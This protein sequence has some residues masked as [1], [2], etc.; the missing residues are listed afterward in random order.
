[1]AIKAPFNFVPLSDHVFFPD[2][3]DMISQ[4]IPFEEGLSGAIDLK[5]TALTPIFVRNGHTKEDADNV[6]NAYTTFSKAPDGRFFI[7]ATSIK[8]CIRNVLE[9]MSFGKMRLDK[10]ARFAQREWDNQTLYPIKSPQSQSRM[11]CGWL[12]WNEK[13][14][15]YVIA[16]SKK[17]YRI[18]HKR[19][20][21]IFPGDPFSI[22]NRSS[23]FDLNQET[24]I[25]QKT[26]DPKTAVYK[27]KLLESLGIDEVQLQHQPF[28]RDDQYAVEFKENRVKAANGTPDFWGTI[29]FTGQPD[30]ANWGSH[31]GMGDGKFY[32]FV[33]DDE[34]VANYDISE[35]T[36]EQYKFIYAD[37]PDWEF[38]KHKLFG[39][40]IPVFFRLDGDKVKDFGLAF[41]YKLP[42]EKT[43]YDTLGSNHKRTD[44]DLADCIFGTVNGQ[45]PL[46][47]R[48]QISNA[49]SSN[50]KPSN[51]YRLALGSPKASYYPLYIRQSG[52][53]GVTSRYMTYNDGTVAGWKR[54]MVRANAFERN[55]GDDKIDT[56]I[57]PLAPQ[58]EFSCKVRFH[59]LL[60]EELGALL[61]AITFHNTN[62]CYHQI[63]Q[64]KPYGFGKVDIKVTHFAAFTPDGEK[65][66]DVI[67]P[68]MYFEGLM[69]ESIKNS[70][71]EHDRIVQLFTMAHSEVTADDVMDYMQLSVDDKNNEFSAAKVAGEYLNAYTQLSNAHFSPKSL[72]EANRVQILHEKEIVAAK[73]QMDNLKREYSSIISS[74]DLASLTTEEDFSRAED[75]ILEA[76]RIFE[77]LSDCT[78]LHTSLEACLANQRISNKSGEYNRLLS[79]IV[80][81]SINT[82]EDCDRA[83]VVIEQ[84]RE[85]YEEIKDVCKDCHSDLFNRVSSKRMEINSSVGLS[86]LQ[87][88]NLRDEYL[89]KTFKDISNKIEQ[90]VKKC[91]W[92]SI[93]EHEFPQIFTAI[94]RI[95]P[96]LKEKDKKE[97][98]R[99]DSAIWK[100]IEL[101][102]GEE[103]ASK[104]FFE[105]NDN[106]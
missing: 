70:W 45:S 86:V 94:K 53:N 13:L 24:K 99:K 69:Y 4:D 56:I 10:T 88:K 34:V 81:D 79:S 67:N 63:G 55:T 104:W 28:C 40:G 74:V 85:L 59:N 19:L 12:K 100:K 29:V 58:T 51:R 84:A 75:A 61:S 68:M 35:E 22:F 89:F 38:F 52:N 101:W 16:K 18:N 36:F 90:T 49:F 17:L 5:I 1:M 42:Y 44:F 47:G 57:Y 98:N 27:Y 33:F 77:K 26:Y 9:I 103:F 78:D 8:G 20:N 41:L 7:P 105:L 91:K 76:K 11:C 62:G 37:S 23:Q 43:P 92:D 82:M 50:A 106:Q 2:W 96:T 15:K 39:T 64:G 72:Y 60:K 87:N 80:I 3:A 71:A 97:W 66:T 25:G 31:R 83:I 95:Y 102:V 93:P 65:C 46:R 30:K 14:G 48:V 6:T 54:Y 21:E 73:K 32:E